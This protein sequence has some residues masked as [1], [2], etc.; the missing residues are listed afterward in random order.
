MTGRETSVATNVGG[1]LMSDRKKL[2]NACNPLASATAEYYV[3]CSVARGSN[4]FTNHVLNALEL[5]DTPLRFLFSGHIGSGKSSELQNLRHGL[6]SFEADGKRFFPIYLDASEYLN[7]YDVSPSDILLSIVAEVAAT[8]KNDLKIEL[9]DRYFVKRT[10]ELWKFL[11]REVD[12]EEV[13]VPLWEAKAKVKLLK[14]AP[15]AREDVR[16]KLLPQ[17][18]TIHEEINLVFDEARLAL[19]NL[20]PEAGKAPY[21][22]IVLILDSLEKIER[23]GNRK[24]G[25]ESQRHLFIECAPQ[26]IGLN[27]HVIYTVPLPLVRSHAPQLSVI[28]GESPSVLPM[29]KVE[30]RK[31]HTPY[32]PGLACLRQILEKRAGTPDLDR[33]FTH[34][35]LNGLLKNC[36][37]HVRDLMAFVRQACTQVKGLPIDIKAV[38]RTLD[39]TFANFGTV[40]PKSYWRKLALLERSDDQRIDSG[41]PDFGRMLEMVAVMEYINGGSESHSSARAVP[42]Y[43]VNPIVRQLPQF[44]AALAELDAENKS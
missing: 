36:G 17:M 2:Y 14:Q 12:V 42:W 31:N 19:K 30:E 18:P 37:G 5:T 11:G 7:E 41:D 26:L 44:E 29:I 23:I 13:E 3:D 21:A 24:Q 32:D 4:A 6:E 16:K 20:K 33:F 40:I 27:A 15:T 8:L 9:K 35:A 34:E 25:E 10:N 1:L 39:P 22:D 28:Y 38:R 43:A